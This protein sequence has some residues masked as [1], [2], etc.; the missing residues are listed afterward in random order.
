MDFWYFPT[1]NALLNVFLRSCVM[2]AVLVFAFK[3][4][5]Y[6]AYWFAIVHDAISLALMNQQ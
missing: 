3:Y 2:F 4:S 6:N 5:Y 1:Q